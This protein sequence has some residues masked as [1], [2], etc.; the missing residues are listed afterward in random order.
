MSYRT[1]AL[2]A[3]DVHIID[4]VAACAATQTHVDPLRFAWENAWKLSAE[5]GWDAAYAYAITE[6][7]PDPGNDEGCITDG[8]IL[9]A[10][11]SL[12]AAEA[13]TA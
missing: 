7:V 10:V 4:R 6:S 5:P 8:M 2:L 13:G 1:Q 11:Q 3:G 9:A 12:I